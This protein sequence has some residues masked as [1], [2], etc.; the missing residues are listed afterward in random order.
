[1]G[2][3]SEDWRVMLNSTQEQIKLKF[4]L[5]LAIGEKIR[6][7]ATLYT[8][9]AFMEPRNALEVVYPSRTKKFYEQLQAKKQIVTTLNAHARLQCADITNMKTLPRYQTKL[10][11][12]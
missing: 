6:V 3:W 5:S 12:I 4:E 10:N 9:T 7:P 1:M 2:G 8:S 11:G